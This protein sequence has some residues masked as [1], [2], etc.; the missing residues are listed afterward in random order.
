MITLSLTVPRFWGVFTIDGSSK[1]NAQQSFIRIAKACGTDPNE[2]AAK[3]WL[4]SSDRPWLLI[5]DNADDTNLDIQSYFPES[6]LGFTLI[7]TRN[8]SFKMHGTIGQRYYHF[9]RLNDSEATDLLLNVAE[10]H[11]PR[12]PSIMQSALAIV[13]KLEALPLA[14]IHAGNAIKTKICKLAD[15]ITEYE[16]SWQLVRQRS[17]SEDE[18]EDNDFLRVYST[19][20]I[21]FAGLK[22]VKK[23]KYKDAVELLQIFAFLH[24]E[25]VPFCLLTAAVEHPRIQQEADIQNAKKEAAKSEDPCS[26]LFHTRFWSETFSSVVESVMV[27]IFQLQYPVIVPTYVRD[28]EITTATRNL[29]RCTERLRRALNALA[30]LSL[31]THHEA[32]DSYSMHPLVHEWVRR[33]PD[34]KIKEQAVW[35]EVARQ[36]ISRSIVLPPL[37]YLVDHDMNLI[38][39]L[40]P[41]VIALTEFQ[42]EVDRDLVRKRANRKWPWPAPLQLPMSP[43]T[44]MFRAKCSFVYFECGQL[45]KA[46]DCLKEVLE[47]NRTHLGETHARTQ[48][49]IMALREVLW[50]QGRVNDAAE[51]IEQTLQSFL[52]ALGQDHKETLLMK[53]LLGELRRHQGRFAES[54]EL[55]TQAKTG[56]ETQLPDSDPETYQALWEL[57]TVLRYCYCFEE[58]LECH[59]R[60]VACLKPCLGETNVLTLFAREE[61]AITNESLSTVHKVSNPELSRRYLETAKTHATFVLEHRIQQIGDKPLATRNA[62]GLLARINATMG[63]YDEAEQL[64]STLVP[65]VTQSLGTDHIGL[66]TH[67]TA[68][69]KML[70]LRGRHDKAETVLQEVAKPEKWKTIRRVGDNPDRWDAVW[71]LARCYEEQGKTD[72]ALAVVNDLLEAIGGIREGR[73]QTETSSVFWNTVLRKK[74]ELG[75]LGGSGNGGGS[76]IGA[77]RFPSE[78][79]GF[80]VPRPDVQDAGTAM[81]SVETPGSGDLRLRGSTQPRARPV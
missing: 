40:L 44:A 34:L 73:K 10:H 41:H 57:G 1:I 32:T 42:R 78:T 45:G 47:F 15:Y 27:A 62:Q 50:H 9:E 72:R 13:K 67:Q 64:Y 48:K 37:G 18:E 65:M 68:Y 33:R 22:S 8:P 28:M 11:E 61:L 70:M 24:H 29:E 55:L 16:K 81:S 14:I 63:E 5:I 21:I 60:A 38:R 36:T 66:L 56:F 30:E 23:R 17:R 53:R 6:E 77:Q 3:S 52:Q 2:R 49:V 75:A 31:V 7:T 80:T 20:E 12:T 69:A 4:S 51:L 74:E 54:I 79:Q 76:V 25:Q 39:R 19:Y 26:F 46:E 58:A 35:C 71:T 59:E 43:W